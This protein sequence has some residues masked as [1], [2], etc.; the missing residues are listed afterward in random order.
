MSEVYVYFEDL[1]GIFAEERKLLEVCRKSWEAQG[2]TFTVLTREDAEKHPDFEAVKNNEHLV[3]GASTPNHL[4]W[5]QCSYYRWLALDVVND[6][7]L[8]IDYDMINYS[9]PAKRFNE[10]ISERRLSGTRYH[11][12]DQF[13]FDAPSGLCPPTPCLI[14]KGPL[15][16]IIALFTQYRGEAPWDN[17]CLYLHATCTDQLLLHYHGTTV[18]PLFWDKYPWCHMYGSPDWREAPVVHYTHWSVAREHTSNRL[19][20]IQLERPI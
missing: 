8:L 7:G 4:V 15:T 13:T 16:K 11:G 1:P 9:L 14:P 2:W 12:R 3:R 10:G 6:G 20:I 19:D 5:E 17:R 18:G